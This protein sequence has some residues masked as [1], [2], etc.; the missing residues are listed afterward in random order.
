MEPRLKIENLNKS[1]G[2]LHVLKD[3]NLEI[4]QGEVVTLLGPSGCGKTTC[5]HLVAGIETADSG[6][7]YLRG[8]S[9]NAVPPRKRRVGMVFQRWALFP[10][11]T[12]YE[13]VAFGLKMRKLGKKEIDSKV[14]EILQVVR[15]PQVTDKFP[16]QLSGGMQQ[17]IGLAR[18]IVV[19]PDILLLDEPFSNLDE[20]LRRE[21]EVEMRRIQEHL[22]ITTLFVTHNQEEALI[23]SDR[24]AVMW[25][26]RI[27]QIGSPLEIYNRPKNEFV[28]TFVGDVNC[29]EGQVKRVDDTLVV[30]QSGNLQLVATPSPELQVGKRALVTLRPER[31]DIVEGHSGSSSR[32][33]SI[34]ATIKERIYKGSSLTYYLDASGTSLQVVRHA[35]GDGTLHNI[36][37]PVSIEFDASDLVVLELSESHD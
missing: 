3:F 34:P 24:V 31:I 21:M 1:F 30:I 22:R 27:V 37:D 29:L 6:I 8:Q 13:N 10:H 9:V 17:R 35:R 15:L 25:D 2:A 5:L 19:E 7:I 36:G 14:K 26:G 33:N 32:D 28:C 12:V 20:L 16:S 18:A 11:M 4:A 23:M